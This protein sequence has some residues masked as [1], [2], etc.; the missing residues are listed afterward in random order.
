M[1]LPAADPTPVVSCPRARRLARRVLLGVALGGLVGLLAFGSVLGLFPTVSGFVHLTALRTATAGG[2][3]ALALLALLLV[4][5][6]LRRGRR[7][8][9]VLLSAGGLTALLLCLAVLAGQVGRGF[10]AEAPSR[11]PAPAVGETL[12]VVTANVYYRSDA[13]RDFLAA[14]LRAGADVV[15]LQEADESV[16]R[17]VLA[18][19]VAT[20]RAAAGDWHVFT[21]DPVGADGV[22]STS[23]SVL[24]VAD[25]LEPVGMDPATLP[26]SA[27]GAH[28]R[29]G[30]VVTVHTHAPV[31]RSL[32]QTEWA[33]T[34]GENAGLCRAGTGSLVLGDFNA[35]VD[36][37]SLTEATDC[38]NA[39]ARVGGDGTDRVG[40]GRDGGGVP[41]LAYGTWPADLPGWTGARIDHLLVDPDA[42]TTRSAAVLDV[43]GSDHRAL[44]FDLAL[45]S[46][47]SVG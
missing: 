9:A 5:L 41:M 36:H 29:L 22:A 35:T 17:D 8:A 3:G 15:G 14:E 40:T 45:K 43:P 27:A 2:V 4:V 34:V 10:A 44:R 13:Y 26:F 7:S 25:H 24:L 33:R 23:A 47:P 18:D 30:P 28:T 39:A 42:Y 21:S 12:R 11:P 16:A 20:G 46:D 6:L 32:V 31:Q 38:V 19:L 37:R 1:T